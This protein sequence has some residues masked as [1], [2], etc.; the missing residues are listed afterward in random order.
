MMSLSDRIKPLIMFSVSSLGISMVINRS[1]FRSFCSYF[2]NK[3]DSV[4]PYRVVLTGGPCAG[5]SSA[6][7]ML[8]TTLQKTYSVYTVPETS[9][10]LLSNGCKYPGIDNLDLLYE[11]EYEYTQ[12]QYAIENAFNSIAQKNFEI[13]GKKTIILYD[14][15]ILDI[16][17][18]VTESIWNRIL[19]NLKVTED[20]ILSRYDLVCHLV[21][22]A[23][24][25]TEF[26]NHETNSSR[27]ESAD[28]AKALD[29]C[30]RNCWKHHKD[31]HV[32]DNSTKFDVKIAKCTDLVLSKAKTFL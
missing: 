22:A 14:R 19:T 7:H 23:D 6:L 27:T 32:I 21:S 29:K 24:G 2:R 17:A 13:H 26:Y 25:A 11:Y 5:K 31:W 15:G 16:K 18:Y 20:D 30:T 1:I 9:T 28:E 4:R 8:T 3:V 12:L 10:I